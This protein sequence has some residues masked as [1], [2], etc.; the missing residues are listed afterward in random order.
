MGIGAAVISFEA[1]QLISAI[2]VKL[3]TGVINPAKDD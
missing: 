2:Y 1:V 3:R